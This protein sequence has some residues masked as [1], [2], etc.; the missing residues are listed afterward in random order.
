MHLATNFNG[1]LPIGYLPLQPSTGN[2]PSSSST[3]FDG[4][5][6]S[7]IPISS[8][9]QNTA[10]RRTTN[11]IL[12][13][14]TATPS[15]T[16]RSTTATPPVII[17]PTEKKRKPTPVS[18]TTKKTP[19]ITRQTTT[20]KKSF[21]GKNVPSKNTKATKPKSVSPGHR[22]SLSHIQYTANGNTL[23][24][25]TLKNPYE[26]QKERKQNSAKPH[27]IGKQIPPTNKTPILTTTPTTVFLNRYPTYKPQPDL[28][29]A[30]STVS[31]STTPLYDPFQFQIEENDQNGQQ[32]ALHPSKKLAFLKGVE[33]L[34]QAGL[35]SEKVR[36]VKNQTHFSRNRR[37][38]GRPLI[39][40][41]VT[42]R[43]FPKKSKYEKE[44]S[45]KPGFKNKP[46]RSNAV[47]RSKL[48]VQKPSA[49]TYQ[50]KLARV[51]KSTNSLPVKLNKTNSIEDARRNMLMNIILRPGG[52]DKSKA[53]PRPKVDV[54]SEGPN[55]IVVRMT[56]PENENIQGL[57]AYTPDPESELEKLADIE[58]ILPENASIERIS[59]VSAEESLKDGFDSEIPQSVVQSISNSVSKNNVNQLAQLNVGGK[60]IDPSAR[61]ANNFRAPPANNEFQE[62]DFDDVDGDIGGSAREEY[63]Y[64]AEND[65]DNDPLYYD[66]TS[67]YDLK[68]PKE[69]IRKQRQ[70]ENI[71]L[72]KFEPTDASKNVDGANKKYYKN[73]N[74]V[75]IKTVK[76]DHI[77]TRNKI[78]SIPSP[79]KPPTRPTRPPKRTP[80]PAFPSLVPSKSSPYSNQ[81]VAPTFGSS[82]YSSQYSSQLS[83]SSLHSGN[84][85]TFEH[86]SQPYGSTLT[87]TSY[88]QLPKTEK[89]RY[90][91]RTS[92]PKKKWVSPYTRVSS[93]NHGYKVSSTNSNL[94]SK[95]FPRS[96]KDAIPTT[97]TSWQT[98]VKTTPFRGLLQKLFPFS[99]E[100]LS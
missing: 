32:S 95:Y 29:F 88:K 44:P 79:P 35:E 39:G 68:I 41:T 100:R 20:R 10:P 91:L 82:A 73:A 93:H 58:K 89:Q 19:T 71:Q 64:R 51:P 13:A 31:T 11:T 74:Q 84:G 9:E 1:Q 14:S 67:D 3:N 99:S 57:R 53:L 60:F 40:V 85:Q 76:Q 96:R 37:T 90:G 54:Y 12:V 2:R 61:P 38:T 70:P 25:G 46:T 8:T 15:P 66:L 81:N 92:K 59:A 97:S 7:S 43:S 5:S 87:P 63:D 21:Q 18:A 47:S 94:S 55:V 78:A 27:I 30:H 45:R 80:Q 77:K 98:G 22:N 28:V 69:H 24:Y 83:P 56:F 49:R 6:Q 52:G 4:S 36:N 62:Y 33:K 16:T 50:Q 23:L 72:Q 26:T 48:T 42:P 34:R 17:R 65:P 75:S 86:P